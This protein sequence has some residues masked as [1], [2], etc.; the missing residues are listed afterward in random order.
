MLKKINSYVLIAIVIGLILSGCRHTEKIINTDSNRIT[1]GKVYKYKMV[2]Q[3]FGPWDE[4]PEM[5][6]YW[7]EYFGDVSFE[8]IYVQENFNDKVNLMV[9]SDEIPDVLQGIDQQKYFEQGI[10]GGWEE[11]FFR[12]NAPKIAKYIDN[13]DASAWNLAKF[14]GNLMYS[15]PGFRLY[16]TIPNPVWWRTDWLQ[17]LGINE[18]PQKL[19]DVEAAF[20]KISNSDP[21][22]NGKK[23][24]YGLSDSG[25]DSIYGAFGTMRGY[26]LTGNDGKVIYGDTTK[27]AKDATAL[28]R[29]WYKDGVLDPEFLTGENQ[30]GY[31]AISHSFLRNR[32]GYTGRG[33]FYHWVPDLSTEPGGSFIS[34]EANEWKKVNKSYDISVGY[35]PIGPEGKRGFKLFDFRTLRTV[36]STNLVKDTDRFARL[37]QVIDELNCKDTETSLSVSR[38]TLGKYSEITKEYRG[39]PTY[40]SLLPKDYDMLPFLSKIGAANTFAFI[41]EGGNLDYQKVI[42]GQEY[43]WAQ[44][45]IMKDKNFSYKNTIFGSLPSETKYKAELDKILNNGIIQI[46]TGDKPLEHYDEIINTWKKSGGDQLTKEAN[47]LYKKQLKNK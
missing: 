5:V 28:L 33:S 14:D 41:E 34:P 1:D 2:M 43:A 11:T 20:Y 13:T 19:E 39:L 12:K 18:I 29:K 40:R 8:L 27:G 42:Y 17:T 45:N 16:N 36:F 47:E 46:I 3:N 6:R 44:E 26:W 10:I 38:G 37:L 7:E 23:D 35:P 9:S 25:F 30:G 4:K 31:W 15:I 22:G 21:D 24:T 32:I